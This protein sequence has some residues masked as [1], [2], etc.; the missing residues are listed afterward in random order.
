M[1]IYHNHI[2]FK[3]LRTALVMLIPHFNVR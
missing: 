2:F 1:L 3:A